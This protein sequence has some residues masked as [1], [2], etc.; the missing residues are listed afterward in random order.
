MH[1][2]ILIPNLKMKL[3][4]IGSG[5]HEN[6]KKTIVDGRPIFSRGPLSFYINLCNPG[7]CRK[8][9]SVKNTSDCK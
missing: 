5:F 6:S 4:K 1:N 8:M 3:R 9:R 2:F 7:E